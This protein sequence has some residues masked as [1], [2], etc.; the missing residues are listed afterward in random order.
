MRVRVYVAEEAQALLDLWSAA[1][2]TPSLTDTPGFRP[3]RQRATMC[4]SSGMVKL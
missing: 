3:R 1:E 4:D 2:A